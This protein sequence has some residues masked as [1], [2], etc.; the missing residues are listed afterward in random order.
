MDKIERYRKLVRTMLEEYSQLKPAYGQIETEFLI[1]KDNTQFVVFRTG[2]LKD[3]RVHGAILHVDVKD[4]KIWIE[5]D[6][7]DRPIADEL[8]EAGVPKED[9]VL[10][11]Q[12]EKLR[13]HTG[14]AVR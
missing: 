2:W 6:G 12:P 5:Y 7:T 13:A 9:I 4:G 10:A 8:V 1:D 14:F 3:A 11:F